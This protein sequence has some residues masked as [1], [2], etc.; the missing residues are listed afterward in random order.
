MICYVEHSILGSDGIDHMYQHCTVYR[1]WCEYNTHMELPP[2][3]GFIGF[4]RALRSGSVQLIAHPPLSQE[5]LGDWSFQPAPE[6]IR[7]HESNPCHPILSPLHQTDSSQRFISMQSPYHFIQSSFVQSMIDP[8][9]TRKWEAQ[10]CMYIGSHL[11]K[12]FR[13][14]RTPFFSPG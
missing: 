4:I 7:R 8:L 14:N 9:N 5:R 11:P 6:T 1:L 12:P 10:C 2:L 3:S 13:N